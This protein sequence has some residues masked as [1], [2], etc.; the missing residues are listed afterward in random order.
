MGL[1]SL[2]KR[3]L[4]GDLAAAFQSLKGPY[5]KPGK[6]LF[7]RAYSII[8]KGNDFKLEEGTFRLDNRKKFFTVRGV[9]HWNRL[10]RDVVDAPSLKAFEARLDGAVSNLVW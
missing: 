9:K 1:F 10:H 2:E 6:E 8:M 4:L 3:R 7:I 5:R